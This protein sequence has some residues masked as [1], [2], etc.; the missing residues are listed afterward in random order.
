MHSIGNKKKAF[1]LA[2]VMIVLLVLTILFAAMAPL[3]TKK[4]KAATNEDLWSW[5][6]RGFTAQMHAKKATNDGSVFFG[7]TP[8][9]VEDASNLADSSKVIIRSGLLSGNNIQRQIQLRYGD[10]Q[11]E[12]YGNTGNI[13]AT[14]LADNTNLLLGGIFPQLV[15]FENLAKYPKNNIAIGYNALNNLSSKVENPASNNVAVGYAALGRINT[16]SNNNVAIGADAGATLLSGSGNVFLGADADAD[17]TTISNNTLIGN[18]AKSKGA[19]NVIIGSRSD[20]ATAL[21]SNN[22]SIGYNA[23]KSLE[24]GPYRYNIAVGYG[25][26]ENL[27]NGSH[28][29]ALGYKACANLVYSSNKTC[30]GA[31]SGP[32]TSDAVADD[33][34]IKEAIGTEDAPD[35]TIRTYIGSFGG[36]YGGGDAPLE[37]HNMENTTATYLANNPQVKSNTT[38][39]VNGNLIVRGNMFLTYG[40]YLYPFTFNGAS[41]IFGVASTK[42]N[43]PCSKNQRSYDFDSSC[44]INLSSDR[45]LKYIGSRF[46]AGLDEI[47]K[48]QVYNYTF[49]KDPKKEPHT[50]VIAQQ[51]QKVFPSAVSKGEDGYLRIRWDEMFYACIN[52]IKTLN[53]RV[54]SLVKRT[55]T[56]ENEVN[57]LEK[58]NSQLKAEVDNI[59]ARV[60]KLKSLRK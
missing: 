52:A 55:L 42:L 60:E 40:N 38:T 30:I 59:S 18:N 1:T 32:R 15:E 31:N 11:H 51:L 25:A 50:G 57:K 9:S 2:E 20:D 24:S 29:V 7:V 19:D 48:L 41:N 13:G 28:N 6:S 44:N 45:R 14:L 56:L 26:L 36:Y 16:N 23:L 12:P 22:T 49:K 58:E 35:T 33:N 34:H 37:I 39:V 5:Q 3:I 21:P 46:N 54:A 53:Q 17:N 10:V 27:K 4:R 47:N 8:L 43:M